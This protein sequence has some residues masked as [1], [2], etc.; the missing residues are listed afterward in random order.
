M[1]K[2]TLIGLITSIAL[3]ISFVTPGH[4]ATGW[5]VLKEIA[6]G[7]AAA[8]SIY[9]SVDSL[10]T[11]PQSLQKVVDQVQ[12][13][14]L[15]LN[16]LQLRRD[17]SGLALSFARIR[18]NP[19]L[20]NIESFLVRSDSIRAHIADIINDIPTPKQFNPGPN[21]L[22]QYH[23]AFE[24]ALSYNYLVAL[25]AVVMKV[26]QYSRSTIHE[27]LSGY[28]FL[29]ANVPIGVFQA[30]SFSA[31]SFQRENASDRAWR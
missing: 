23:R 24:L 7:T 27:A 6:E 10:L 31:N 9:N 8:L 14:M 13:H 2:T 25:T 30:V 17:I 15:T 28:L 18:D 22:I 5:A 11:P 20:H 4:S 1:I 16:D 12:K 26:G 3:S 29:R 19:N 21:Q